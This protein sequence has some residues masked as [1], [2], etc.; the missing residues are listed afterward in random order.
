MKTFH[1]YQHSRLSIHTPSFHMS[2]PVTLPIPAMVSQ[3]FTN[4]S[5]WYVLRV[6]ICLGWPR[7]HGFEPGWLADIFFKLQLQPLIT[8][9]PHD[10]NES[11]ALHLKDLFHICWDT[12]AQGFWKTFKVCNLGSKWPYFNRAY[13]V[14][15]WIFFWHGCTYN[16]L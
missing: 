4:K 1:L 2:H 16:L 14:T 15:L 3:I 5:Y 13:V 10:E 11:L 7:V 9:K 6:K 8:L 12:K